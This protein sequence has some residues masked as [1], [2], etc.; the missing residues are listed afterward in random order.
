MLWLARGLNVFENLAFLHLD[1]SASFD[2]W[3][4]LASVMFAGRS[5]LLA[6]GIAVG[7][8]LHAYAWRARGPTSR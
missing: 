6:G 7:F 2:P 1:R 4:P 8:G 5:A 3:L